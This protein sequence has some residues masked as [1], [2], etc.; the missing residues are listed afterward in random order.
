[1]KDKIDNKHSDLIDAIN[2]CIQRI[3]K[4]IVSHAEYVS[5]YDFIMKMTSNIDNK[6]VDISCIIHTEQL[7][8]D[9]SKLIA[10]KTILDTQTSSMIT[11]SCNLSYTKRQNQEY[12]NKINTLLKEIVIKSEKVFTNVNAIDDL[13][14]KI[15]NKISVIMNDL[16][17]RRHR[18]RLLA[19]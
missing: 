19:L 18:Q 7:E 3:E 2:L 14:I 13:Q 5:M 10:L 8:S 9:K 4:L 15:L 11:K 6:E 16:H 17:I 1:M 12:L